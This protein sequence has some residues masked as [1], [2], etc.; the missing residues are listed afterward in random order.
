MQKAG[1]LLS[2]EIKLWD[3]ERGFVS[4]GLCGVQFGFNNCFRGENNKQAVVS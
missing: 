3:I 4:V 1:E 2:C